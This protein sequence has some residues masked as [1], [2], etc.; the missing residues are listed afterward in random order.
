M[1]YNHIII[2]MT[3]EDLRAE[4]IG[5]TVTAINENN[6]TLT[7]GN[8]TIL[9]FIDTS[10]CCA[11]F[12]AQLTAGNLTDNAITA[13]NCDS[14]SFISDGPGSF[15]IHILAAD[16]AIADLSVEGDATSGYYCHSI[17]L[18]IKYPDKDAA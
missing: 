10:D 18:G 13:V 2:G 6:N 8:G 7:L 16:Q 9:T 15:T 5:Q 14:D 4:L 1:A 12:E 3:D 17:D 11:W